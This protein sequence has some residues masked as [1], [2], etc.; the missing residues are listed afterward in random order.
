M[1]FARVRADFY[2]KNFIKRCTDYDAYRL[3]HEKNCEG[4]KIVSD[5]SYVA[6]NTTRH[7]LDFYLPADFSFESSNCKEAFLI[8]HGGGFVY[9][10]K[11][12][13]RCF[14]TYLAKHSNKPVVCINYALL[15]EHG[16]FAMVSD[17]CDAINFLYESHGIDRI[18]LVGDSAGAYLALLVSGVVRD[19][20]VRHDF[21]Y[22]SSVKAHIESLGLISGLFEMKRK[23]LFAEYFYIYK[24]EEDE[25]ADLPSYAFDL[26][27]LVKRVGCPR[28]AIITGE[29]DDMKEPCRNLYELLLAEEISAKYYCAM[30]TTEQGQARNMTHVFPIANP[31]WPEGHKTISLITANSNNT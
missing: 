18:H 28:T 5:I 10:T 14:G 12:L 13:D 30:N 24:H 23:D 11:Q 16:M 15:P 7:L 25:G 22:F 9:G 6:D 17:I 8:I 26:S 31:T 27:Q 19:K 29:D 21:R 4:V 20:D 3:E 2:R 1:G